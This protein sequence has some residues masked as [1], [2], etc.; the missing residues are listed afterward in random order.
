MKE[1]LKTRWGKC[2]LILICYKGLCFVS[3]SY[4]HTIP[5]TLANIYDELMQPLPDLLANQ[6]S[7]DTS[8]DQSD[9]NSSLIGPDDIAGPPS[10]HTR[11]HGSTGPPSY[12]SQPG[13]NRS[14]GM[15]MISATQK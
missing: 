4:V 5:K 1:I 2:I 10:A 7:P 11:S 6:L 3:F 13:S 9:L 8:G 14:I 12:S 15:D